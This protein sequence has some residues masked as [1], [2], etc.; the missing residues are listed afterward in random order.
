MNFFALDVETANADYSSICQIGIAEFEDGKIIDRWCSLINPETYFDSF[1]TSIHGISKEDIKNAPTF[2]SIY[3]VIS[4]KLTGKITIHHMPFD[5]IAITRACISYNL[6]I[7]QPKWLDSAKI[8]KRT[9]DEFSCRGYG[10]ANMADHLNIKFDHHDA[11]EDAITAG[12]IVLYACAKSGLSIEE[13][14]H[15]VGHTIHGYTPIHLE[16][17]SEGSLYGEILVFT[18]ALLLSRKD[19]AK[20]AASLGCNVED[21]VTKKTTILI[22]GTQDSSKLAGYEKS[23]KHRRAEDLIQKGI[24]IKILS[25][26]DFIEMCK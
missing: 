25:E 16:G 8:V 4:E 6:E 11:L 23:S 22:V 12:Q 7:L 21:S 5:K 15:K 24:P 1:N 2:E 19:A 18:G 26:N 10:L 9:W 17:D 13:W 20:F 3:N 14:L